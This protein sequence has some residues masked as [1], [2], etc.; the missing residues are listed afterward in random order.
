MSPTYLALAHV[1]GVVFGAHNETHLVSS[2]AGVHWNVTPLVIIK[3]VFRSS[4]IFQP[5]YTHTHIC[6]YI[7]VCIYIC[8][9]VCIYIYIYIHVHNVYMYISNI[10]VYLIYMYNIYYVKKIHTLIR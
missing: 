2:A 9:C 4:K 3:A 1:A 8:V 7:C 5:D 10:H 6:V